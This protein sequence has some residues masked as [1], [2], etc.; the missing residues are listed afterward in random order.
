MRYPKYLKKNGT[1]GFVAPSFGC[2]INPYYDAFNNAKNKFIYMGY[3]LDLGPNCYLGEGIGISNTP[4]KCG[5]ELTSYYCSKENDV[6]LSCGGGELMCEILDF[7]D[8]DKIKK[9]SP[10]WYMGY[11]DNTNFTFL[12]TT[13]CDTASIYGPCAPSFG[14]NPWHDSLKDAINVI[15]G[16]FYGNNNEVVVNSYDLWEIESLKT[17]ET[18]YV[19]Y[20]LTRKTSI[21]KYIGHNEV[22]DELNFNGRLLGGCMDCLKTLI[23]TRYDKV[24][25]FCERY[26]DDGIIWFLESCELN[27]MDIRRTMWQMESAGWFSNVKGFII[28]RPMRYGEEEFGINQ[29]EAVLAVAG[30]YNVPIVMDADIGHLPPMMPIVTGSIGNVA[31]KGDK[32]SLKMNF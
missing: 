30:K 23:G 8:F 1:I 19:P 20:N 29:Y 22:A 11:S 3:S 6:L 12:L 13:L 14:M 18:P 17:P 15:S 5:D 24:K 10:K 32:L 28:G 27:L 31:T 26:E 4:E 21:K 16:N 25:E 2:S 9:S 7:V